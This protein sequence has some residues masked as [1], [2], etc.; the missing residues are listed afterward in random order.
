MD[1]AEVIKTSM[2][3]V[4]YEYSRLDI[5]LS[6]QCPA[7]GLWINDDDGQIVQVIINIL[8]KSRD[9]V[10][11]ESLVAGAVAPGV[12]IVVESRDAHA[13]LTVEDNGPGI[14]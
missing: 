14:T 13:V 12:S 11:G 8:K 5:G 1:L 9:S 3:L 10:T 7:E 2:E 6:V 4:G